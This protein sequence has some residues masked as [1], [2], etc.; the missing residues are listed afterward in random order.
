MSFN[1]S[2]EDLV[3]YKFEKT[4]EGYFKITPEASLKS[5]EYGFVPQEAVG[6]F[7]AGER[8]YTFGVD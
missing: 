6:F 8:V 5:G 1:I 2:E 3:P 7:A 4:P